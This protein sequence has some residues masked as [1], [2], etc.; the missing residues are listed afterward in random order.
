M[1]DGKDCAAVLSLLVHDVVEAVLCV[2]A[3]LHTNVNQS[4]RHVGPH[5]AV[6]VSDFDVFKFPNSP[7]P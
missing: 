3:R 6:P 1:P 4:K 7:S 2:Q 5:G